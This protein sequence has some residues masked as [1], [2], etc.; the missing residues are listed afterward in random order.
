MS[1]GRRAPLRVAAKRLA[2]TRSGARTRYAPTLAKIHQ[3]ENADPLVPSIRMSGR[4]PPTGQRMAGVP[5]QTVVRHLRR[6][7]L[8]NGHAGPGDAELLERFVAD[9]DQGAFELLLWRHGA[10][11]LSL[12]R[13]ILRH[14]QE[15]EDAFQA[16]FL[17]LA[18]KGRSVRGGAVAGWLHTVAYRVALAA[19]ARADR[20][21]AR[22][23]PLTDRHRGGDD[24]TTDWRDLQPILDEEIARLPD[25]YRIPFVLYYLEGL[26]V[27]EAAG[28]LGRPRGTIGVRLARARERL[29]V[30]L[31]ARGVGLGAAALT[32]V[33]AS[34]A[35]AALSGALVS[36]TLRLSVGRATV[37]SPPV[38]ALSEGVIRTMFVGQIK[39][40]V[41]AVAVVIALGFGGLGIRTLAG[42]GPAKDPP[43]AA[44]ERL[45]LRGW[46]AAIDPDGD[47][48]FAVDRNRLTITVP[49]TDHGLGFER[50]QMN[51]PRVLQEIEGDFIV[52]VR[53]SGNFP[54]GA[55]S[56]VSGRRPFFGAGILL[57]QND[58]TYVRL[59]RAE[60]NL[61]GT[62]YHY[63]NW[64]L[65]RDGEWVR[66]GDAQ[67]G[68]ID[69]AAPA[70]LRVERRGDRVYGYYS[71]DGVIWTALDPIP[72]NLPAKVRVGVAA[73]HNTSTAYSP[74]FEGLQLYRAIVSMPV[75]ADPSP[76]AAGLNRKAVNLQAL[77]VIWDANLRPYANIEL[78][79][80]GVQTPLIRPVETQYVQ[81]LQ[82]Y[83]IAATALK[84]AVPAKF[85]VGEIKIVGS[86]QIAE[87]AIRKRLGLTPGQVITPADVRRAEQKLRDSGIFKRAPA[88]T[89]VDPSAGEFKTIV[90]TIPE[91]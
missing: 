59:E 40:A 89:A 46:G 33:L 12:C 54:K 25:R 10:M 31:S 5:L 17:T 63:A 70:W 90:V 20:R 38:L 88:V 4:S 15:A 87:D 48:R 68:A 84:S 27:D 22:E 83:F 26:T 13:R 51:A 23:T 56:V 71:A 16:T 7:A 62:Q 39:S 34:D 29:R 91:K 76:P 1:R 44:P 60:L 21:A 55:K 30:R 45:T 28:R 65:R 57:Y 78:F 80:P 79:N 14:E 18:R 47:C 2:A 58:K 69:P 53:V 49:G 35:S 77:D 36:T 74:S 32:A 85:K 11:V 52:Q 61:D 67:D 19:K 75:P 73:G 66:A 37:I 81:D 24:A 43:A 41:T 72:V 8:L 3:N 42:D 6:V 64:E 86:T 9:Q 82:R 50:G